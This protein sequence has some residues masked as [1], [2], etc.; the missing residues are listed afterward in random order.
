MRPLRYLTLLSPVFALSLVACA[1]QAEVR[2]V[3]SE[4]KLLTKE[5][6]TLNQQ[7]VKITQ[8][9]SLNA[10]STSGAYLLPGSKTPAL[11]KSQLGTLKLTLSNLQGEAN[12]SQAMLKISS[13]SDTPLPAFNASIEWG[14][15]QG[16]LDNFQEVN[17]QS[18]VISAPGSIL[19]PT[20][21]SIPLKLSGTPPDQVGF[22]RVHDIQPLL[23]AD[24]QPVQ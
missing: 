3:H 19:A 4:V 7:T 17:A 5:M 15:I 12:G 2:Q 14:Q 23:G 16:T 6:T 9:N 1:P 8:Q 21:V 11:L 20:D 18:Q 10:K 22:V 24:Q 13:D